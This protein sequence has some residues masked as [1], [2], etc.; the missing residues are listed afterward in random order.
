M[1]GNDMHD[2]FSDYEVF[3]VPQSIGDSQFA[4]SSSVRLEYKSLWKLYNKV[5]NSAIF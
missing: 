1:D 2:L 4:L 5:Q 3:G